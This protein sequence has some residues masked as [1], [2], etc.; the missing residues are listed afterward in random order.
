MTRPST[1]SRRLLHGIVYLLQYKTLLI[2][3]I[4]GDVPQ[5]RVTLYE[6]TFR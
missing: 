6:V 4:E 5:Q 3:D 2:Y 1:L